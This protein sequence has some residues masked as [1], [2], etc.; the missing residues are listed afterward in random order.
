MSLEKK[1][2]KDKQTKRMTALFDYNPVLPQISSVLGKHFQS[3]LF[4]KAELE[5]ILSEAPMA[6]LR[7]PP[8]LNKIVFRAKLYPIS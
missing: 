1:L 3:M 4:K 6:A 2:P 7:Q 5:H 8:N